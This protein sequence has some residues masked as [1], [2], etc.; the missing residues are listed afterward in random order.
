MASYF[1]YPLNQQWPV[2]LYLKTLFFI[3]FLTS[4]MRTTLLLGSS[5]LSSQF[6]VKSFKIIFFPTH[7][8]QNL[9]LMLIKLLA[10]LQTNIK[11]DLFKIIISVF[12]YCLLWMMLSRILSVCQNSILIIM[13]ILSFTHLLFCKVAEHSTD[14]SS[15]I[16]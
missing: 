1:I 11:N 14:S 7:N 6:K 3:K 10:R 12:C 4:S 8:L 9:L 2:H 5:W 16:A 15:R 13:F